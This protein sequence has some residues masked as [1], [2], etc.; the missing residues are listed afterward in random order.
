MKKESL[1][2][3]GFEPLPPKRMAPKATALD[4]SAKGTTIRQRRD[5]SRGQSPLDF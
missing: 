1:C 2:P 5:N 3:K 4:H